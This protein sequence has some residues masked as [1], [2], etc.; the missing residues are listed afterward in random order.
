MSMWSAMP[1]GNATILAESDT[2]HTMTFYNGD[3]AIIL[4]NTATGDTIDGIGEIGVDPGAGLDRRYRCHQQL[5]PAPH[6]YH[7]K[8]Q[9]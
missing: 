9:S 3:D 4:V 6:E 1:G 2:T 7:P 5:Y 8:G